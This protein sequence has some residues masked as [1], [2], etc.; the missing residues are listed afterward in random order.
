VSGSNFLSLNNVFTGSNYFTNTITIPTTSFPVTTEAVNGTYLTTNY[1]DRSQTQT[2]G[3]AKTFNGSV[4]VPTAVF[5]NSTSIAVNGTYLTANYVPN[6]QNTTIAGRKTFSDTRTDFNLLSING[7]QL[8]VLNA[9]NTLYL[10]YTSTAGIIN[11]GELQTTGEIKIGNNS[12]SGDINIGCGTLVTSPIN[13]GV[14][15]GASAIGIGSVSK[16]VTINGS[17][18]GLNVFPTCSATDPIPTT[19]DNTLCTTNF[20]QTVIN[21]LKTSLASNIWT[22]GNSFTIGLNTGESLPSNEN[23]SKI[24]PTSWIVT[25]F[26]TIANAAS[27]YLTIAT[28]ALTYLTIANAAST[29]LTIATA[30]STYLTTANAASTYLTIANAASTYLTTANA[31][32]TYLTIA[33]AAST[34]L[35][36]ATATSTYVPIA[37]AISISGLKTFTTGLTVSGSAGFQTISLNYATFPTLTSTQIGYTV[38]STLLVNQLVLT[39]PTYQNVLSLSLGIGVW[40]CSYALR[41][42]S[43]G[44]SSTFTFMES[45]MTTSVYI[46]GEPS[47]YGRSSDN[48]TNIVGNNSATNVYLSGSG[49]IVC[50]V[51]STIQFY[52]SGTYT[53]AGTPQINGTAIPSPTYLS[54]TRIA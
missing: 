15:T 7:N 39:S 50:S 43:T 36:T 2:I 6:T 51:A 16:A 4:N 46:V 29:Y 41:L 26:L 40:S 25:Y 42:I 8:N 14:S 45:L 20:V 44:G 23:S 31:A 28:A 3:G 49:V 5:P 22:N 52:F 27:T 34:Y 17:T 12:R 54:A 11:I 24:P 38:R 18:I 37:G 32:S 48:K 47:V 30:A 13:I 10:G 53:T 9:S 35:T 21:Y 19:P 1:V 33:N